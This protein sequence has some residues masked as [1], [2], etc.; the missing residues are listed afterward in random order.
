MSISGIRRFSP[1]RPG[2]SEKSIWIH[3]PN[4]LGNAELLSESYGDM[5]QYCIEKREWLCWRD[6][7]HVWATDDGY[8]FE[9]LCDIVR[10]RTEEVQRADHFE[11]GDDYLLD[12]KKVKLWANSSG[13]SGHIQS[14]AKLASRMIKHRVSKSALDANPY[15]LG[16]KNGILDLRTATVRPGQKR[17]MMTML[18]NANYISNAKCPRFEAFLRDITLN[19]QELIDYLQEMLGYALSGLTTEQVLFLLLGFGA[20]GKST[21]LRLFQS[22]LGIYA[23]TTPLSTFVYGEHRGIRSDIAAFQGKRLVLSMEMNHGKRLDEALIKTAT[24]EDAIT[25][26]FLYKNE[27]QFTSEAKII[28]AANAEPVVV[29]GDLGIFRRIK[30]VPFDAVFMGAQDNKALF[31]EL[32]QETDGIL[33][34]AVEGFQRW[35]SR[36][37][38]NEPAI[39]ADASA[40]YKEKMDIVGEFIKYF[41]CTKNKDDRTSIALLFETFDAWCKKS[42]FESIGKKLFSTQL[43]QKGLK[44]A[45]SGPKRQFKGIKLLVTPKQDDDI[46]ALVVE[47]QPFDQLQ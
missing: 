35:F 13:A 15:L 5:I 16:C 9:I 24:G 2:K 43:Q 33:R 14:L 41:C 46:D 17:D 23:W 26:R 6:N 12:S 38:L 45:K 7:E 21:F 19:R 28:I 39:V 44:R 8:F 37:R 31:A 27:S 25:A 36:G 1:W 30:V 47:Q 34:W 22:L 3:P 11:T 29:G 10:M 32:V 20:N 42:C 4:D 18:C 40:E